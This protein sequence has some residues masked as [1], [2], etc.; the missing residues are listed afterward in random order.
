[1][2]KRSLD[3]GCQTCGLGAI[4]GLQNGSTQPTRVRKK[5]VV[6]PTLEKKRK[7]KKHCDMSV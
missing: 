2:E 7:K 1:M 3:Q 5:I 6:T 4:T